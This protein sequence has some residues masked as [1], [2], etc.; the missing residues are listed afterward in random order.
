MLQD[1]ST[2]ESRMRENFMYGLTGRGWEPIYDECSQS[3]CNRK[4]RENRIIHLRKRHQ[5]F[6]LLDLF[7]LFFP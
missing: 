5:P 4:S 7:E 2:L 1:K 6:T 3:L